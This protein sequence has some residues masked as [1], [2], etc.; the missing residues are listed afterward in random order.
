MKGEKIMLHSPMLAAACCVGLALCV[1]F[2]GCSDSD[3][4][5]VLPDFD[6][7]SI[8]LYSDSDGVGNFAQQALDDF[9][10][11]YTFVASPQ[12][13]LAQAGNAYDLLVIE[14][15][16]IQDAG[17]LGLLDNYVGDG[18]RMVISTYSGPQNL[19]NRE[20]VA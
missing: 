14:N 9:G 15:P 8:L 11:D 13:L 18:G 6:G 20:G 2:A 16:Y 17:M 10:A 19:Y 1:F 3:G 12:E 5:R 4:N 7:L